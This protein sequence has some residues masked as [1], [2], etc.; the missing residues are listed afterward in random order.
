[1]RL[2]VLGHRGMLGRR[3]M[4]EFP[5]AITVEDR[6]TGELYD[7]LL[8][9][10]EAADPDWVINCIGATDDEPDTWTVNAMLPR[11]LAQR[12]R[13]IQPST[14]HV[15][16][17]TEYAR[18]KRAG[19][20]GTVIRC[21]IVDPDGGMLARAHESDTTGQT[22]R[23]WNGITAKWWARIAHDVIRERYEPFTWLI[24]PGSPTISHFDLLET[25]RRTF[26]WTTR[27]VPAHGWYWLADEPD[28]LLPPIAEQLAEYV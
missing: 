5:D 16:D 27:T 26:R 12:W 1:M 19:E 22:R 4:E 24:I 3:V 14:D 25:A 8:A 7:P 10:V 28:I 13:L 23:Q 15:H 17:D 6:F 9:A 20:V 2:V 21:A 18:S 11:R